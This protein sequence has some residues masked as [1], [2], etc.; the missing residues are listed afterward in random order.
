MRCFKPLGERVMAL[1]CDRQAAEL[2]IRAAILNRFM[3][4]GSPKTQR[5]G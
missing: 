1:D 5:V 2:Q 4:L 3:A